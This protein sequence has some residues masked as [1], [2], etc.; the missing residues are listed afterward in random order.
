MSRLGVVLT[1]VM[2]TFVICM[3]ASA[4]TDCKY[5]GEFLNVG[6]GAR[7]LGMGGAFVAVADDGTTAYWSPGGLPSLKSREVAFMYCQQFN[8]LVKTNFISYV[9]PTSRWGA[10]GVSWLRLGVEDIPKTGYVDAN[11]NCMQDFD[12]KND[13]GVKD[14]GELYIERP[15]IVGSFDDIEDGVF[16]SYGIK[17][18]AGFSIGLN[19]KLIRQLL[20]ANSSNGWGIDIGGLYELFNGF[21]VGLNL[22]DVPC[23]KLKWDSPTKHEDVIPFSTKLGAA[24]TRQ[25]SSLKSIFT[26][27]CSMDTR[28]E[29]D[30]HYGAEWWLMKTLAL[31]IGLDEGRLSMGSG[32]RVSTFQVDYAFIGHDDLG[33]THRISTSVQF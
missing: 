13:N 23:T 12:D 19:L 15:V 9:H 28:Y 21:K 8:S 22:Q 6:A 33:N 4:D 26:V 10:F 24:Y 18:S 27:S 7:A 32:L 11:E 20:A 16:F 5:A 14:P 1:G 29:T 2:I 30:M 25:I 17:V 3:T 31:R